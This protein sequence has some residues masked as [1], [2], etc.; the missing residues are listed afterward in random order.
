MHY[1]VPYEYIKHKV[2][3]RITRKVIEI[4]YKSCRI[5]SHP[6]LSGKI[7]QYQTIPEHM[8]AKHQLYQEWNAERFTSWAK[9]IG[10]HTETVV[11]AILNKS[12]VEQQGYRSCMWLIKAADKYSSQR[13]ENAC[14]RA[15]SFTPSPSYKN[16]QAILKS[17]FDKIGPKKEVDSTVTPSEYAI[18]RG[19]EY[20]GRISE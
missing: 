6:R 16:V 19:P 2:D 14:Q 4:F 17:G 15:L 8:P 1:S 12:K 9:Q 18:S 5:A 3:I 13:L 11:K 20:Y 10:E 7:G